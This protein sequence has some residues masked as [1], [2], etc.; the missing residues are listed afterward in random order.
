M[1]DTRKKYSREFKIQAVRL[2]EDGEKSR[3][4][5]EKELGIGAGQVHRWRRELEAEGERA[6]PGN[7]N[8]RDEELAALR[9]EVKEL[10]EDR[11]ILRKAVAIFSNNRK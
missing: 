4:Q 10:R 7:G 8:P 9:K 3:Q 2:L 11:E 1:A 5:I 6:F